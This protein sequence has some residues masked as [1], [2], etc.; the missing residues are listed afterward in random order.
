TFKIPEE[1][2]IES[3]MISKSIETAQKRIEG[4]NFDAR[5]QVLAYDDV[6]NTQRLAIYAR[7]RAALT[8]TDTEVEAL[9]QELIGGNEAARHAFDHKKGELGPEF[10]SHLRRLLLQIIDFFWL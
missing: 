6:M 8:G 9:I 5:K 3:S 2:P 1:E 10:P 7:R 4:F